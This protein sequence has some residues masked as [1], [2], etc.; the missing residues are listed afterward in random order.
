MKLAIIGTGK[1]VHEALYAM[2]DLVKSGVIE[3]TS[4]FARPHSRDKA[5][6]LAEQYE[7]PQIYTD[8]DE[9]LQAD[10]ADAVYIGLVNSVHYEY[11][12]KALEHGKHVILEKPLVST[13]KEAEALADCAR[14]NKRYVLE[15][16]TVLHNKTFKK[17]QEWLPKLGPIKLVQ[18]NFSQYSSRYDRYLEGNVAPAFDPDSSGGALYDINLYNI[19]WCIGLFGAPASAHYFPNLGFNGIDTSGTAILSYSPDFEENTENESDAESDD[20]GAQFDSNFTAVCTAAK[21][22]DSPCYVTVQGEKGWMRL[23]GKPNSATTSELSYFDEEHPDPVMSAAGSMDR[24]MI[25]ESFEAPEVRH[26]MTQEFADFARIIDG[27]DTES[28]ALYLQKSLEVI[29]TLEQARKDA[30]I[31]FAVD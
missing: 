15:A 28:A 25:H 29:Q 11:A 24:A 22:S 6:E 31:H 19:Y 16:I 7:I 21:D 18:A 14:K 3:L 30:G 8:Y 12:Q 23:N 4:I 9:L 20:A 27:A 1:I 17:M 2:D 13:V 10:Q 5:V 26:R